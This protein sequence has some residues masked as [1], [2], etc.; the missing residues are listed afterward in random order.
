MSTCCVKV[1]DLVKINHKLRT[2]E[3]RNLQTVF[4]AES[5]IALNRPLLVAGIKKLFFGNTMDRGD[6]SHGIAPRLLIFKE[7]D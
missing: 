5:K 2:K 6:I 1:A 7:R 4:A 3:V